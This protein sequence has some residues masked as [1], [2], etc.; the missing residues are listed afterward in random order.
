MNPGTWIAIFLPT[1][2]L[3]FVII[4]AEQQRHRILISKKRRK[5]KLIMTNELLKK[6]LGIRC[7]ISTGSFGG[8]ITGVITTL[9]DNWMEVSTKTGNHLINVEYVTHIAQAP[10]KHK[11][12]EQ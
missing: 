5:G 12:T 1:F 9:E 7:N 10:Q 4:P 3:L 2:I 6:Y 8:T 11:A